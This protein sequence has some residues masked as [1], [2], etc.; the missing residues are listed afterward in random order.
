MKPQTLEELEDLLRRAPA[1]SDR[2]DRPVC[3]FCGGRTE[4]WRVVR[5]TEFRLCVE[6]GRKEAARR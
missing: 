3:P 6:C 4:L 2:P 5:G 1:T